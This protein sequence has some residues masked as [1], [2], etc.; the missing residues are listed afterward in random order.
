MAPQLKKVPVDQCDYPSQPR[1]KLDHEHCLRLGKSMQTH[2]Q[3]VP[4]IGHTAV[5]RFIIGDGGCRLE[6]ARLV[7]I[8]ELLALDLGKEP[9]RAELLL[10]QASIDQHRQALPPVDRARLF[11]A[12]M[13]E[14]HWTARQMAESVQVSEA[15]ISRCLALLNL[16][17][18]V[19]R[20]VNDGELDSSKAYL[21]TQESDPAKQVELAQLART[22]SR[23]ALASQLRKTAARPDSIAITRLARVKIVL[24]G[25][26]VV[27]ITGAELSMEDVVQIL[28]DTLK[29]ARKATDAKYDVKTWQRMMTDRSKAMGGTSHV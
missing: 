5:S 20:L 4:I 8:T 1:S 23:T 22:V 15:Q 24:P 25:D 18:E 27:S 7:G 19:Q 9:T 14:N 2:G 12:S 17:E 11:K 13:D 6:G 28:A 16:P 3:K 26:S 10:A 21:L 29:E